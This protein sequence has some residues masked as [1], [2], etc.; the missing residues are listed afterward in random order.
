MACVYVIY[1]GNEAPPFMRVWIILY[2]LSRHTYTHNGI[3]ADIPGDITQFRVKTNLLHIL[4]HIKH[5]LEHTHTRTYLAKYHSMTF[6]HMR[7]YVW[8]EF[9]NFILTMLP[10]CGIVYE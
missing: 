10:P 1:G 2:A 5:A 6:T 3:R 8:L 9:W 4:G 7:S